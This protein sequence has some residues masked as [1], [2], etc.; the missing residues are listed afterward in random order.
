MQMICTFLENSFQKISVILCLLVPDVLKIALSTMDLLYNKIV[1]YNR[2][3]LYSRTISL[4]VSFIF[5]GATFGVFDIIYFRLA[6]KA[7]DSGWFS[8]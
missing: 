1:L 3:I 4:L 7:L 2:I 5:T 8:W 6:L